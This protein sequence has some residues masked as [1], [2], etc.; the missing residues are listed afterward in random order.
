E[1]GNL[2]DFAASQ[3]WEIPERIWLIRGVAGGVEYL[4]GLS[5]PIYHGDLKSVNI[6]VTSKC[7]AVITDFGSARRLAPKDLDSDAQVTKTQIKPQP[8][9]EFQ[10]TFCASTSTM[11]LTGNEYTLRWAAPELL[12]DEEHDLWSDIWALGWIFYEVMTNSIPFQD[13]RKDSMVIKHVIEGKLPSVTD[14][15]RMSLIVRLCSVMIK[16]WSIKPRERPTAEDCRKLIGWMPMVAP[17][18]QR[19]SETGPSGGRSPQLLMKLGSMYRQQSDYMNASISFTEALE[20]YTQ[21]GNRPGRADALFGLAQL[22]YF[23][24]EHDE[25]LT[26][27]SEA[28]EIRTKIGD[29]QGRARALRG[30][31]GVHQDQED[32]STAATFYSEA[33]QICSDIGDRKGRASSLDGLAEVYRLQNQ[34]SKAVTLYSEVAEIAADT[35]DRSK[36]AQALWSL[37]EIHCNRKEYK[38]AATMYSEAL[39]I[40]TD[41]GNRY[42]QAN[43]LLSLARNHHDQHQHIDA[44]RLY[45]QALKIFEQIGHTSESNL[46]V[47]WAADARREVEPEGV[48]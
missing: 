41:I 22:H 20:L 10:A 27:Y 46:A 26:L 31:A 19:A 25:A 37:A 5:P 32:Y 11:T 7:R 12:M 42:G 36:R 15:T 33:A 18:T 35:G 21:R 30:L 29:R 40:Y 39:N 17:D 2:K 16:C 48:E 13:V 38:E 4:H 34:N 14:H 23:R 43:T 47:S 45:D 3:D 28:L 8:V 44:I 1:N 6:L 24:E 9:L